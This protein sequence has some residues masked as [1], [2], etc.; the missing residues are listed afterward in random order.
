MT[1]LTYKQKRFIDE[2]LLSGLNATQAAIRAGYSKRTAYSIGQE[3]LKKPE[4]EEIINTVLNEIHQSQRKKLIQASDLAVDALI[5]IVK[6][7]R[8]NIRIQA[9]NSILDRSGHKAPDRLQADIKTEVITDDVKSKLFERL[10]K[11]MPKESDPTGDIE[12]YSL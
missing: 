9:A 2:Y 3:N 8:E 12:P 11:Q 4:I 5:D 7:G 1:K 6:N 10:I